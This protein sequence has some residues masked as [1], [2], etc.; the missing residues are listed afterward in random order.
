MNP[1]Q[2]ALVARLADCYAHMGDKA[3]ARALAAVAEK[4]APKDARV[5]LVSA[6]V[7]EELGDRASAMA[8]VKMAVEL[9]LSRQDIESTRGLDALRNDPA[10]AAVHQ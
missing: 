3:K 7:F 8:R 5:W 1:R 10:Y 9:G 4:L 6:Q 2:A